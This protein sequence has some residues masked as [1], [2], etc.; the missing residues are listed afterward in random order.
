MTDTPVRNGIR[1]SDY[2]TKAPPP[3]T[4]PTFE[5][6]LPEWYL[7]PLTGQPMAGSPVLMFDLSKLTWMDYSEMRWHPQV[8]ASLSLM[9]FMLHQLDW[10]IECEEK[11]IA[12]LVEENMRLIWT[13]LIRAISQAYWAGF[14]PC[15]LEWENTRE[16][17]I[18]ISKIK[19]LHPGEANVHWKEVE[20]TY[21]PPPEY[22][23]KIKPKVRVFDGIDKVGLAYPIPP[24]HSSSTRCSGSTTITPGASCSSQHSLPGSSRTWCTCTPIATSSGSESRCR[25]AATHRATSSLRRDRM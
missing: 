23:N 11:K 17:K 24:E 6:A 15:V 12:D 13:P 5:G 10:T 8:N 16:D 9:T 19:D 25:S 3:A 7:G 22:S 14:S 18:F 20:S 1:R 21:R 4:G 2:F